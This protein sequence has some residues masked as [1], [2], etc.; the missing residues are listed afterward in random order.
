MADKTPNL[1]DPGQGSAGATPSDTEQMKP[2]TSAG[3]C[4]PR[5]AEM[6]QKPAAREG[7]DAPGGETGQQP[8]DLTR[9]M[10]GCGCGPMMERMMSECFKGGTSKAGEQG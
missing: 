8:R 10:A 7:E 9:R 2:K 1:Q 5:M 3:C 4:G 6:M